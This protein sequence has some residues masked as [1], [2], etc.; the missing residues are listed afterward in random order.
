MVFPNAH[1][2]FGSQQHKGLEKRYIIKWANRGLFL[3]IFVLFSL[4]FQ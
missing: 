4:Q 2:P 3:F 1:G